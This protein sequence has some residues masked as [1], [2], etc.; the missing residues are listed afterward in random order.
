M[1]DYERYGEYQASE[2]GSAWGLGITLLLIGLGAGALTALLFAPRS[3]VQMRRMLRRKYEDALET[4]GERTDEWRERGSDWVDKARNLADKATEAAEYA[5]E[6][7]T[8][9]ARKR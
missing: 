8:P 1:T 4:I 9:L 5:R 6:K 7:V 3:G 2:R